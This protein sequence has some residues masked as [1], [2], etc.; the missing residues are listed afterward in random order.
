MNKF[1]KVLE[2]ALNSKTID[3]VERYGYCHFQ[4]D[5]KNEIDQVINIKVY[6]LDYKTYIIKYVDNKCVRFS[7][8]TVI[9]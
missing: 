1:E 3:E 9:Q 2:E 8:I 4:E 6:E 7:D 5:Y